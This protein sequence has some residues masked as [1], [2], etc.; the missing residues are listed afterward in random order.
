MEITTAEITRLQKQYG[1][2]EMQDRIN[3]GLAWK[4]EGS[5]GR[6]AMQAL[7][8]GA[9]ML[10]ETR[11]NDYYGNTVPSRND[12]KAGTKGTLQNSQEFWDRVLCCELNLEM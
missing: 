4:L 7:E 3:S 8:S 1:L 2:D 11:H 9:C 12:L 6:A 5:Y 10:P